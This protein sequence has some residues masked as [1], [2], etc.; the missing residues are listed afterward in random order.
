MEI[1]RSM[2]VVAREEVARDV[3]ALGLESVDGSRMPPWAPGA[4]IELAGP[5]GLRRQYSLCGE[6]VGDRWQ[7]AV[8]RAN[9]GRGGSQWVHESL[10]PG[11]TVEVRGPRNHFELVEAEE[12]LLVAGGIGITPILAMARVLA[13]RGASWQVAYGGRSRA[14]MAFVDEL[15]AIAGERLTLWPEEEAGLI[16]LAAVLGEPRAGRAIYVCGPEPLIAAVEQAAQGRGE[17]VHSERFSATVDRAGDAFEVQIAS[18]GQVVTV[19]AGGDLI[20]ALQEAGV[21]VEF[22]CREGTCGTCETGVLGGVPEHRDAVLSEEERAA[23]D[24]MMPCVS[25]C[26]E[27][28]LVLDL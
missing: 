11:A 1:A 17:T 20:D 21:G 18:T 23:N 24:V 22:S 7:V 5:D 14:T 3:V 9:Q 12:Y 8:L 25:R 6:P 13:A 26:L 27:G 4:H 16:D 10:V 2:R 15:A 19:P 28:P